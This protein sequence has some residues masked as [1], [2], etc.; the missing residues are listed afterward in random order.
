MNGRIDAKRTDGILDT[1]KA[2]TGDRPMACPW[3]AFRDPFVSRVIDVWPFYDKGQLLTAVPQPSFRLLA[4]VRHY[5]YVSSRV[6]MKKFEQ[7]KERREQEARRR[8]ID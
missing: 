5:A 8:G 7:D 4:G 3:D 6:D 1:V 2:W